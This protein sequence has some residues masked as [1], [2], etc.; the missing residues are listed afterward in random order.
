MPQFKKAVIS[1]RINSG[2]IERFRFFTESKEYFDEYNMKGEINYT[3]K[4]KA[5]K[6]IR[7]CSQGKYLLIKRQVNL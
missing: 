7:E 3:R 5:G 1:K 4:T 6:Q 2:H